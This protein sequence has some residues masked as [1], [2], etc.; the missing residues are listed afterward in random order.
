MPSYPTRLNKSHGS[1]HYFR[2]VTVHLS[3]DVQG[4][5]KK[6]TLFQFSTV[7]Y[8]LINH[9]LTI[10]LT[11]N[12]L[13]YNNLLQNCWLQQMWLVTQ[14]DFS[15]ITGQIIILNLHSALQKSSTLRL[16]QWFSSMR[17]CV[18]QTKWCLG[19]T[20]REYDLFGLEYNPVSWFLFIFFPKNTWCTVR[21][22]S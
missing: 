22:V 4:V 18:L 5:R 9:S 12:L 13:G 11:A 8:L 7:Y 6:W 15:T 1:C 16:D 2:Q 19:P 3:K 17:W 20:S 21:T 10:W 14:T